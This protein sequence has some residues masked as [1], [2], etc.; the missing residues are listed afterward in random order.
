MRALGGSGG[1]IVRAIFGR[2]RLSPE[3]PKAPTPPFSY[4]RKRSLPVAPA[5]YSPDS[6][7][8]KSRA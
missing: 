6:E 3:I 1:R 7:T 8:L 2:S 5:L 4:V